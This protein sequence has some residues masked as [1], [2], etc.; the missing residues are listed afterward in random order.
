MLG[1][2]PTK[3]KT[4][5]FERKKHSKYKVTIVPVI[6]PV[7]VLA[8][9]YC[10]F[11]PRA[12]FFFFMRVSAKGTEARYDRLGCKLAYKQKHHVVPH[13]GEQPN[14]YKKGLF[15][16]FVLELKYKEQ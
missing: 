7:N 13:I 16:V 2:N 3:R 15:L 10:F 6:V 4:P 1:S 11:C 8:C 5:L 14:T 9:E 12:V